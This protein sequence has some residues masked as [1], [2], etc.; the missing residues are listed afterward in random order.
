VLQPHERGGQRD[1]A[2]QQQE[3]GQELLGRQRLARLLLLLLRVA[4]ACQPEATQTLQVP[5][6]PKNAF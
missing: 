6:A 2:Q 5:C 4:R 1:A 3:G